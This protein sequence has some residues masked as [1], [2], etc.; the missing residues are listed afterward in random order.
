MRE[1]RGGEEQA[2]DRNVTEATVRLAFDD[3]ARAA[4]RRREVPAVFGCWDVETDVT[5]HGLAESKSSA[6]KGGATVLSPRSGYPI[7]GEV[8]SESWIFT[9]LIDTWLYNV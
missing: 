7:F 5:L 3:N 6:E 4:R 2:H 9:R 8:F 1:G